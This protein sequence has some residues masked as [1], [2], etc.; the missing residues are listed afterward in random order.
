[1]SK[2]KQSV[3]QVWDPP[4]LTVEA[5]KNLFN[6]DR[7]DFMPYLSLGACMEGLNLLG[8]QL[9]NIELVPQEILPGETWSP[10]VY[11]ISGE[12]LLL[13]IN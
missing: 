8:L 7:N 6:V 5:K 12:K 2:M 13:C 9:F 10:E 11:K 3:V 1:M 4:Y